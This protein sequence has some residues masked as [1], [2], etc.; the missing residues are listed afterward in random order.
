MTL[1]W[2]GLVVLGQELTARAQ[3]ELLALLRLNEEALEAHCVGDSGGLVALFGDAG[4]ED[5]FGYDG[6]DFDSP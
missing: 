3:A 2:G 5:P 1:M 6:G 4:E